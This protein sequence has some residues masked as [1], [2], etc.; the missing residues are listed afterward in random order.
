MAEISIDRNRCVAVLLMVDVAF[1]CLH[2][3]SRVH[4]GDAPIMPPNIVFDLD[5]EQGLATWW[6]QLKL[7]GVGLAALGVAVVL[8]HLDVRSSR[9]WCGVAVL[10]L[11]MSADE[12]AGLH[13]FAIFPTRDAF[14]IEN[15]LL[16]AA[17][18]IPVGVV[19]LLVFA[20]FFRFWWGL[21]ARVRSLLALGAVMFLAGAVGLEMIGADVVSSGGR[22][23][24]RWFMAVAAEEGLEMTGATV[25]LLAVLGAPPAHA[26]PAVRLHLNRATPAADRV[27]EAA[28]S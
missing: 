15:G 28:D 27:A 7:A 19:L 24:T 16:Y 12:S 1:L 9:Y 11:L 2:L 26:P 13:E 23:S 3:L 20:V 25:F 14:E 6:Q 5:A 18:V 22:G 17:W 21:P 4:V 10:A 8:R